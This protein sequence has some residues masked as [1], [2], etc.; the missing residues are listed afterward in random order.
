M[1]HCWRKLG[2]VGI[3]K[4]RIRVNV[5]L[6]KFV[7]PQIATSTIYQKVNKIGDL[8]HKYLCEDDVHAQIILANMP[9]NS[10]SKVQSVFLEFAESLG[11]TSEKK[12]LF[13]DYTNIALRPDYFLKVDNSGILIEVE[14]GKTIMN[15]MDL[16]DFWKCH[17]CKEADFLFLLVPAELK[18]NNSQKSHNA[19]KKVVDRMSPLFHEGNYT[20]VKALFIF[21]Y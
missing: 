10:S 11:F 20:N 18:Q 19:F 21:G 6:Q 1:C 7:Q 12:G 8:L 4:A 16:L 3:G 13:K 15:N 14:R 9:G 5:Q 17:I 2:L